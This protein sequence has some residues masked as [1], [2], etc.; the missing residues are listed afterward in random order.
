MTC[1]EDWTL[2]TSLSIPSLPIL[3]NTHNYNFFAPD[4]SLWTEEEEFYTFLIIHTAVQVVHRKFPSPRLCSWH[5]AC[6]VITFKGRRWWWLLKYKLKL[7]PDTDINQSAGL[8]HWKVDEARKRNELAATSCR[9]TI[10]WPPSLSHGRFSLC[11]CCWWN[12][13]PVVDSTHACNGGFLPQKGHVL[14]GWEGPL[15]VKGWPQK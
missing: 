5:T 7:Y 10:R 4:P 1:A 12:C 15:C 14:T 9:A 13:T 11:V 8:F 2:N 6:L 3:S